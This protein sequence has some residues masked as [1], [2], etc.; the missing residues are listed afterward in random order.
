MNGTDPAWTG[1]MARG[2]HHLC[3][4]TTAGW[5][6]IYGIQ[7]LNRLKAHMKTNI[8]GDVQSDSA[9]LAAQTFPVNTNRGPMAQPPPHGA[10][11]WPL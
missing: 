1:V 10:H 9:I 3:L 7:Y 2:E 5:H 11:H 8:K 6:R 4:R